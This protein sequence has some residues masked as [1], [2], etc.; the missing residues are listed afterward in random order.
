MPPKRYRRR[1]AGVRGGRR[2]RESACGRSWHHFGRPAAGAKILKADLY[3]SRAPTMVNERAGCR[4]P[5][6]SSIGVRGAA[7]GAP[8]ALGR[9]GRSSLAPQEDSCGPRLI[10]RGRFSAEC[11]GRPARGAAQEPKGGGASKQ[12]PNIG[13]AGP[14]A[15][16]G[17]LVGGSP[18]EI[19]G[20]FKASPKVAAGG[21]ARF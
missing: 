4:T 15:R 13:G 16:D 19:T 8:N 10:G 14:A 17:R 21:R 3:V 12:A 2:A 11:A 5:G 9:R 7:G 1:R 20:H 18:L 6:A